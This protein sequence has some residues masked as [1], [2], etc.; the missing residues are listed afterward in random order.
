MN[1]SEAEVH[2]AV[3]TAIESLSANDK[4]LL[5]ADASERSLSHMLAVYLVSS[6]PDFHVDCEYNRDGFNVKKLMLSERCVK[7]DELEAVTVFPD[8]IIHKRG[9]QDQNLLVLEMKKAS[10]SVDH[11]YDIA[12]LSAFKTEL[13]YLFAVHVVIGFRKNGQFVREV[14]W[15]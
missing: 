10:S 6:F 14:K 4:H 1:P 2:A 15:Q 3:Q 13:K 7:D 9:S 8:I 5:E 12:K 11:A